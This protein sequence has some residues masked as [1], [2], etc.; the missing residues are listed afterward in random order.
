MDHRS[1]VPQGALVVAPCRPTSPT[2]LAE[3]F[4]SSHSSQ[5]QRMSPRAR[6]RP[7]ETPPNSPSRRDYPLCDAS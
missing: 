2:R 5:A 6:S 1:P 4:W 7:A 3:R